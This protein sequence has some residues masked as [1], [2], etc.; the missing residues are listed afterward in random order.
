MTNLR[1][2]RNVDEETWNELKSLSK[3]YRLPMGKLLSRV[4][5]SY[6]NKA[7]DQWN[8][9]LSFGKILSDKEAK[10][11]H[12]VVVKLRKEYGFREKWH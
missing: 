10:D 2:I 6:K 12:E 11:M 1:T 9:L 3:K 7:D 4:I 8:R 5:S